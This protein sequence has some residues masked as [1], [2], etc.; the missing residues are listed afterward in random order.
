MTQKL[1]RRPGMPMASI[2]PVAPKAIRMGA[3]KAM[4]STQMTA[5]MP[6][7]NTD[8]WYSVAMTRLYCPAP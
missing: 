8:A 6:T 7:D 1:V 3:G 5:V 4:T 2:S